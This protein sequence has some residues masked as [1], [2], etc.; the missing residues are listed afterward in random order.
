MKAVWRFA[1]DAPLEAPAAAA[2]SSGSTTRTTRSPTAT[3]GRP[4]RTSRSVTGQTK[5]I[6]AA[7]GKQVAPKNVVVMLMS[8]APLN[9]GSQKH[10]LEAKVVGSGKAWIATNGPNDRGDVEEELADRPTRFYDAT[11]K[12]VTL[13]VGQTFVQVMRLGSKVT[14]K[15]AGEDAAAVGPVTVSARSRRR[16]VSAQRSAPTSA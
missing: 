1:P 5:Q 6:D 7:D 10:R 15:T 2:G 13:T 3:T 14:I 9:D 4:T 8:F 11:G 12:P 16:A